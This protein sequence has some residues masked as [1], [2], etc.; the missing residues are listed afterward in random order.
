MADQS[1]SL[2]FENITLTGQLVTLRSLP[3][4]EDYLKMEPILNDPITM[5]YI[6]F[7]CPEG[8]WTE[9]ILIERHKTR[10]QQAKDKVGIKFLVYDNQTNE[11]VGETSYPWICFTNKQAEIG[12][13]LGR[14]AAGKGF[15]TEAYYL[16]LQYGFEHLGLNRLLIKTNEKN[17]A[18]RHVAESVG[19]E[20]SYV[21][22]ESIYFDDMFHDIR[23]YEHFQRDWP[24]I[25]QAFQEKIQK[26]IN[27]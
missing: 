18:M 23:V 12:L 17:M 24:K 20:L 4:L 11:M 6:K 9:E 2:D 19:M 22:R 27:R 10:V 16:L 1:I 25:E 15:G 7:I 26:R 8:G 5:E 13:I 21:E 14:H 3:N